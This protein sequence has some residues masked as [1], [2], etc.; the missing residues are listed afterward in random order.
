[1][2]RNHVPNQFLQ[3]VRRRLLPLLQEQQKLPEAD[4]VTIHL[5][6]VKPDPL[7]RKF[8]IVELCP[9]AVGIVIDALAAEAELSRRNGY[10]GRRPGERGNGRQM[11]G[12][13]YRGRGANGGFRRILRRESQK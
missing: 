7:L 5:K 13:L 3:F 12:Q 9:E 10:G 6:R 2:D 1:M 4:L 11:G 8:R